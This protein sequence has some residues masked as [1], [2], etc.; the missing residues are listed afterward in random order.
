LAEFFVRNMHGRR[1]TTFRQDCK[2]IGPL[3]RGGRPLQVD[4]YSA[5]KP[6]NSVRGRPGK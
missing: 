5:V 3:K 2:P 4:Q 6:T 1:V